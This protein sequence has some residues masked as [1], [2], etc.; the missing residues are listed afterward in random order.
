M[1]KMSKDSQ[2]MAGKIAEGLQ[3]QRYNWVHRP[4][5]CCFSDDGSDKRK[6]NSFRVGIPSNWEF[7]Y[8]ICAVLAYS[9]SLLSIRDVLDILVVNKVFK[10]TAR[11]DSVAK[12]RQIDV[13]QSLR[14]L[15]QLADRKGVLHFGQ[16]QKTNGQIWRTPEGN[17]YRKSR[18]IYRN[19]DRLHLNLA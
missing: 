4:K 1:C 2:A 13:G 19:P 6:L 8:D 3:I 12:E 7:Q 5:L 16:A 18:Q 11:A 14:H 10:T 9:L 17:R 15:R